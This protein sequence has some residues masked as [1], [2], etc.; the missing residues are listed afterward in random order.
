[1]TLASCS[2][3]VLSLYLAMFFKMSDYRGKTNCVR[4]DGT[5]TTQHNI[6]AN[7]F[8]I[9]FDRHNTDDRYQAL[10]EMKVVLVRR[11][12][13]H[14]LKVLSQRLERR[15]NATHQTMFTF[16]LLLLLVVVFDFCR[17]SIVFGTFFCSF[18]VVLFAFANVGR[19]LRSLLQRTIFQRVDHRQRSLLNLAV[20][21]I[22]VRL[23]FLSF[24][25]RDSCAPFDLTSHSFKNHHLM[26]I[27][28]NISRLCVR[29]RRRSVHH[30][31]QI[32][33][34]VYLWHCVVCVCH[35]D[36]VGKRP[37]E[38]RGGCRQSRQ[39]ATRSRRS[40]G[41]LPREN[42]IRIRW[43]EGRHKDLKVGLSLRCW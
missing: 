41:S 37:R 12:Q 29:Q 21:I 8:G 43:H 39:R 20:I 35:T 40:G 14:A 38:L 31:W 11:N 34:D 3:F 7:L 18:P 17:T 42:D 16:V 4:T 19:L 22:H 28:R 1:M 9:A 32:S 23:S 26:K 33:I 36:V 27:L 5:K 6:V 25:S 13:L 2:F 24:F 15:N 30:W 10:Y